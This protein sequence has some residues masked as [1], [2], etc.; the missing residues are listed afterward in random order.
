MPPDIGMIP[1]DTS[2][3]LF[4]TGIV[5]YELITGNH[6]YPDRQPNMEDAP[7]DPRTYVEEL[8]PALAGLLLRAVSVDRTVRYHSARRFRDDLLALRDVYLQAMGTTQTAIPL[9][10]ESWEHG[11]PNYNPYV[12]RLLT[13][14]SQARRDNSGT[15]GLGE[16]AQ[17][18]YVDTRL[19]RRLRPAVLNGQYRLVIITGNAGDGKTAFI[20]KLEE[21]VRSEGGVVDQTTS[22]SSTFVYH[23][24]RFYTN[25]DGSQ[26]EGAERANDQVLTEFFAGFADAHF[27]QSPA[28]HTV[29]LI[30]INEGRL[31]DFFG[32]PQRQDTFTRLDRVISQF[33][34]PEIRENVLPEWMLIID[35]NQRSIVAQDP[36]TK[37]DS[38]FE[39]QLVALLKPEFW[40][41]CEHCSLKQRCF[42]KYNADTLS[43]SI[44]G[45]PVRERL[46]TLFEIIHLRRQLHITMRD[47]RSSLSWLI[48]RDHS[49]EDVATVLDM[50]DQGKRDAASLLTL[51]YHNAYAANGEPPA[52]RG[53]DRLVALLRQIDPAEV[54]NPSPDRVLHFQGA[55]GLKMLTF[56]HR[57]SLISDW[58]EQ[59]ELPTGWHITQQQDGLSSHQ[60]QHAMMRRMAFFER[61]DDG[62]MHMLPYQN[63]DLFR[64]MTQEPGANHGNL[65]QLLVEGISL[66]EGARQEY[67]SK[68]FICLRASTSSGAKIKSFRLFPL[69][70]FQ[71]QIPATRTGEYLEYTP[72]QIV[73]YHEPRD[74]SERVAGA[75]RAEL[76]VSLDLLELLAQIRDGFTPSPDDISGFFI[77][78]VIFKNAL[79]HLPYRKV[80]LTRDNRQFYELTQDDT[81][82]I[83]LQKR[84]EVS[85]EAQP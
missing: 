9:K 64:M 71:V 34:D 32:A 72:D 11:K 59:W 21:I 5:L 74:T 67:L 19:D 50:Y 31:I 28:A 54:A 2:C 4:A 33:F 1:W 46:R 30:A 85:H 56:E 62:W 63:L 48:F 10:L 14:Y 26:D 57:S 40:A 66:A 38:I 3:D 55:A 41:P 37:T 25:Y 7:T 36:D 45:P 6:P 68:N 13:L 17:H 12:T 16:I 75:R 20:K 53:D 22:N 83:T 82:V 27:N 44:S 29:H 70:D 69:E 84:E 77:N 42:I 58:M 79:A 24:V 81:A 8:A 47:M 18:T 60:A 76:I 43:N 23:G 15:R 61:R 80:L 35:L 65:K 49:C 51:L 78:L 52:E 73:F 39:R